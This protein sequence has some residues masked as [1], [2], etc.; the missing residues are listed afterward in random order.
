MIRLNLNSTISLLTEAPLKVGNFL[1]KFWKKLMNLPSYCFNLVKKVDTVAQVNFESHRNDVSEFPSE[2]REFSQDPRPSL[3]PILCDIFSNKDEEEDNLS[4]FFE[5]LTSEAPPPAQQPALT[6]VKRPPKKYLPRP[7]PAASV[8]QGTRRESL[9]ASKQ[10]PCIIDVPGDGNCQLYSIIKGLELQ[11]PE[12]LTIDNNLVTAQVLRQKGIE[13]IK[14]HLNEESPLSERCLGYIDSDRLEYNDDLMNKAGLYYKSDL[15][16]I[17]SAMQKD[18]K[19]INSNASLDDAS[20]IIDVLLKDSPTTEMAKHL[21]KRFPNW[22][23]RVGTHYSP[24]IKKAA[25]LDERLRQKTQDELFIQS[26][27]QFL[28]L[29]GKDKFW[30]STLHLFG[31][32][33]VLGLP[34]AVHHEQWPNREPEIFNAANSELTPIHLLRVNDSHY[35]YMLIL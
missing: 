3:L 26:N 4:E 14:Q 27:E 29:C 23:K 28:E 10:S 34:L 30:C 18:L 5:L 25:R 15:L 13:F 33:G 2:A 24:L 11:Y 7:F 6:Q 22:G 21:N 12:M 31:L 32:S 8:K 35:K 19:K 16:T 9:I 20:R 1:N 17:E